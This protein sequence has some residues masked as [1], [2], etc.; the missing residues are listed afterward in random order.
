MK[1]REF[2]IQ[3]YERLLTFDVVSENSDY[4]RKLRTIIESTS[5]DEDTVAAPFSESIDELRACR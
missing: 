2:L 1:D 3:I 5:H 4:M